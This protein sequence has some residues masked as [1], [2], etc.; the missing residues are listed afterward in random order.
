MSLPT[1]KTD[2]LTLRKLVYSDQEQIFAYSKNPNVAEHVI[3]YP[4]KTEF[5]TIQFLNI[6]YEAYNHNKAA[7]WGIQWKANGE[8]IGTA[9]FVNWDREKRE[10]EI[11]YALSEEFW[12]R[13]IISEAVKEIVKFGF[14][15]MN[16]FK[17]VARC[18][19]ANIGSYKVLEKC[20]FT[21]NGL[22]ENQMLIKGELE[23]MRMYSIESDSY[24]SKI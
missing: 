8:I 5:D 20:R 18:K 7:P 4:H 13:G 12:K 14:E 19:P 9:G 10:A 24:L 21:Y 1:L 11:G 23:D 16:L 2:R 17:I 22:I 15:R 6:V 3:W